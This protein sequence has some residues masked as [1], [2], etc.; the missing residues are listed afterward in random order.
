MYSIPFTLI[1]I[2]NRAHG[3]LSY[4]GL[5]VD[6]EGPRTNEELDDILGMAGENG[7]VMTCQEAYDAGSY[8]NRKM[9]KKLDVKT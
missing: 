4:Q 9:Y 8:C 2:G 5:R 1:E 6:S 7:T 3:T